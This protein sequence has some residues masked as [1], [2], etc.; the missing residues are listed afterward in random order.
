MLVYWRLP[1]VIQK[2]DGDIQVYIVPTERFTDRHRHILRAALK[3]RI[4]ESVEITVEEVQEITRE[5]N[6]KY[7]PVVSY[8]KP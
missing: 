5:P 3:D 1:K 2:S 7:R 4:G 6:G 8:F